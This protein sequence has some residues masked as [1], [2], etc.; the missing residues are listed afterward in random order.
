[1]EVTIFIEKSVIRSRTVWSPKRI[2]IKNSDKWFVFNKK[3]ENPSNHP[4]IVQDKI[5]KFGL[6]RA[7][8]GTFSVF[9]NKDLLSKYYD[10]EKDLFIFDDKV[11]DRYEER[12][13][14]EKTIAE[15]KKELRA[16]KFD[17]FKSDPL[18]FIC[19][20]ENSSTKLTETD[21]IIEFVRFFE[22]EKR[23]EIQENIDQF[24]FDELVV[25][26]N[27][28]YTAMVDQEKRRLMNLRFSDCLDLEH[29][30]E[31]KITF[32]KNYFNIT[33]LAMFNQIIINNFKEL[34]HL[35]FNVKSKIEF[36]CWIKLNLK[37]KGIIINFN[38]DEDSDE[39]DE[40]N[41]LS[42]DLDLPF[43]I[44]KF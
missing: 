12:I 32:Y 39:N 15:E 20:F 13:T 22:P 42:M 44:L 2:K 40:S 37:E 14:K 7:S 27:R 41:D 8:Y 4:L 10:T 18:E 24:T 36:I 43:Q 11:L 38:C 1:M 25:I 34:A 33:D 16:L 28:E 9:L 23:S 35:K 30:I 6:K 3:G 31:Q 29:F 5:N 26:F 17:K 19:K 21:K